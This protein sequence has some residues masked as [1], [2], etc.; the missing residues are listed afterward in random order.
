M[1]P[2]ATLDPDGLSRAHPK[3]HPHILLRMEAQRLLG[4]ERVHNRRWTHLRLE[5]GHQPGFRLCSASFR[6][7]QYPFQ[8]TVRRILF[9]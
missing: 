8:T 2:K 5:M 7:G 1:T 4:V 9:E 6:R 3:F